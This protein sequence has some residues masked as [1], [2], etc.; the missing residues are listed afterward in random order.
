MRGAA[1]TVNDKKKKKRKNTQ[2]GSQD[3]KR[4]RS[5]QKDPLQSF[6]T[7][8]AAM[9]QDAPVDVDDINGDSAVISKPAEKKI[10]TNTEAIGYS[11]S[12]RQKW[13]QSH[14]KGKFDPKQIKKQANGVPGAFQKFKGY[15]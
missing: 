7:G 15:K 2:T 11:T 5:K 1:A 14:K 3:S 10:F 9:S 8:E 6:D 13:K 4:Q 12:G